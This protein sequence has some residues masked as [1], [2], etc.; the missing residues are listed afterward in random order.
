M[1]PSQGPTTI[2]IRKHTIAIE[3]I[4]R[5]S[6]GAK[7]PMMNVGPTSPTISN[8]L[9][10]NKIFPTKFHHLL[11]KIHKWR[12]DSPIWREGWILSSRP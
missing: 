5:I 7:T 10:I 12:Q 11:S 3:E 9:I 4:T 2:Y 6:Q 1:Q 8:Q